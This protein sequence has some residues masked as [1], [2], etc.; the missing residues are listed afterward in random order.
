[1]K[2]DEQMYQSLLSRYDAYQLKKQRQRRI[3]RRTVP[4]AACFCF[5]VVLGLGVWRHRTNTP[6]VPVKP[7]SMTETT[8]AFTEITTTAIAEQPSTALTE[9]ITQPVSTASSLQTTVQP[10]TTTQQTQGLTTVVTSPVS[11]TITEQT[12]PVTQAQT[13]APHTAT[14][15][16]IPQTAPFTTANTAHH[17]KPANTTTVTND[18]IMTT[19]TPQQYAPGDQPTEPVTTTNTAYHY[20]PVDVVSDTTVSTASTS[21]TAA[22]TT[23]T[24]TVIHQKPT[25]APEPMMLYN[26][27]ALLMALQDRDTYFPGQIYQEMITELTKDGWL[28]Q[29][30]SDSELTIQ[31]PLMLYP[32]SE[33]HDAGIE[34]PVQYQGAEYTV[35]FCCAD[36]AYMETKQPYSV[37]DSRISSYMTKRFGRDGDWQLAVKGRSVS[38]Y[39][40]NAFGVR[41]AS[42]LLDD[43]HYVDIATKASEEEVC[44]FLE[45]FRFEQIQI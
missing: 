39:S 32:T 36:M 42:V 3:I 4:I 24:T 19:E 15:P 30:V 33:M 27:T 8:T 9:Q 18:P 13:T 45:T 38:I 5:S 35:T 28:Y 37:F 16:A 21:E 40:E 10:I 25:D 17:G 34:Y 23:T 14:V 7:E 29:P 11:V 26:T 31:E 43:D 44:D 2:N 6:H 1:M 12:K 22:T 20:K 41:F